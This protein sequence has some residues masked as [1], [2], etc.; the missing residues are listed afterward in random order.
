MESKSN[1]KNLKRDLFIY[2]YKANSIQNHIINGGK[3]LFFKEPRVKEITKG[4][5]M[6]F[7]FI[8]VGFITSALITFI[9]EKSL[10]NN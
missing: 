9:R 3:I 8:F 5:E 2:E 7:I 6:I 4:Y 1:Y 10:M